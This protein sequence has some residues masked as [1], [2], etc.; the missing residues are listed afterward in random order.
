M[1]MT[2][3]GHRPPKLGGYSENPT[4]AWAMKAIDEVLINHQPSL[5]YT[6]MALGVDQWVAEL[7]IL[8]DIKF[9]AALPS[10]SMG[11]K[12]PPHAV[13]KYE[14]LLKKASHVH[15]VHDTTSY[16]PEQMQDRNIWMVDNS[17]MVVSIWDGSKGGTANCVGYAKMVKKN[18]LNIPVPD[19]FKNPILSFAANMMA[20]PTVHK[21]LLLPKKEESWWEKEV[22]KDLAKPD[23][24][25]KGF[26]VGAIHVDEMNTPWAKQKMADLLSHVPAP[27]YTGTDKSTVLKQIEQQNYFASYKPP[28]P[29][30]NMVHDEMTWD[31]IEIAAA[32][33]I[34]SQEDS[35]ILKALAL[36]MDNKSPEEAYKYIKLLAK[37][38]KEVNK[39]LVHG[40]MELPKFNKK[41]LQV[42]EP[43]EPKQDVYNRL[44]PKRKID[45]D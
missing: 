43:D 16:W 7:C 14:E 24:K 41:L 17:D 12:W 35:E 45:L 19:Q 26:S 2:I 40:T 28:H 37:A 10:K 11:N 23:N 33:N 15:I 6:G 34:E 27:S 9:V 29:L 21:P 38:K 8:N 4:K 22:E 1:K 32:K 3:C 13:Q 5:V 39:T 31:E 44:A 25:M 42:G 20:I 18:Y 30:G 36:V